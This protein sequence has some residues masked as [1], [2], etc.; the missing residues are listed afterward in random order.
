[1]DKV[2]IENLSDYDGK[3]IELRGWVY[4]TR[5]IGKIWFIIDR[6]SVV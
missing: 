1:M 5:S 3:E 4:N 2:T 6:K